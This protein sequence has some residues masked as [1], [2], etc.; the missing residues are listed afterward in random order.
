MLGAEHRRRLHSAY[1]L[2]AEVLEA[3]HR[4]SADP[5]EEPSV[6]QLTADSFHA[7]QAGAKV[8]AVDL[9]A[10]IDVAAQLP[11]SVRTMQAH[12]SSC[13]RGGKL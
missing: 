5:G 7:A 3:E 6:K 1:P 11:E 4:L 10:S 13:L 8:V 2:A 12:A 9:G